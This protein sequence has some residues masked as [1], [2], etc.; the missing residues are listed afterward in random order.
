MVWHVLINIV[1]TLHIRL[2]YRCFQRK[3]SLLTEW[4]FQKNYKSNNLR[5]CGCCLWGSLLCTDCDTKQI[6][7]IVFHV[8]IVKQW[9]NLSCRCGLHRLTGSWSLWRLQRTSFKNITF[10]ARGSELFTAGKIQAASVLYKHGIVWM[11]ATD[12]IFSAFL[13]YDHLAV[14][15][16]RMKCH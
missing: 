4:A 7:T 15:I 10:I 9:H 11:K 3:Y 12:S 13:R 2:F 8:I 5:I 1:T 14:T 16:K 6:T